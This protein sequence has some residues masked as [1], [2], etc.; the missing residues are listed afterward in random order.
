[1][2]AGRSSEQLEMAEKAADL[3]RAVGDEQTFFGAE[4]TRGAALSRLGR[5]EEALR[6]LGAMIPL[7][8]AAGDL[9]NLGRALDNAGDAA[10][11]LGNFDECRRYRERLLELAERRDDLEGTV[12]ALA[13]LS[14]D[15][16]LTGDWSSVKAYL[17]KAD[18]ILRSIS[19]SRPSRGAISLL[20]TRVWLFLAEG[21]LEAASRDLNECIATADRGGEWALWADAHSLLAEKDLLQGRSDAALARLEPLLDRPQAAEHLNLLTVTWAY[22]EQGDL[23]R[24]QYMM[25]RAMT[26]ATV[27]QDRT[28]K[29]ETMRVQGMVQS[30]QGEWAGAAHSFE[31]ALSLARSMTMPYLEGRILYEWGRMYAAREAPQQAQERLEEALVI[32][33]RLGARPYIER[34]E[35]ALADSR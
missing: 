16:F 4:A 29:G 25:T 32:F 11:S 27:W 14:K 20:L 15:T 24:A 17:E 9:S 8:E 12:F 10:F 31:E 2:V 5:S 30:R 34:T 6:T 3:A 21:E 13:E 35:Q 23:V 26:Q 22:L 19:A 1:M 33:R 18:G 28:W 7:A